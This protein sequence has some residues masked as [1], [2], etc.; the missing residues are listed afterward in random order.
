MNA[1]AAQR[2]LV[3]VLAGAALHHGRSGDEQLSSPLD[4]DRQV[5]RAQPGRAEAGDRAEAGGDHRHDGQV[6]DHVIPAGVHRHVGVPALLQRLHAAAAA[7]ALDEA[8]DRQPQLVGELLGVDLLTRDRGVGRAAANGEVVAADDDLPAVDAACA[9]DEVGGHEAFQL[10]DRVVLS[11]AGQRTD[12]AERAIV[13]QG[14]DPL[15]DG[16]A[17]GVVLPPDLVRAAHALSE[18]VPPAELVQLRLPCH[19]DT[20]ST[21]QPSSIVATSRY[22][23]IDGRG[24]LCWLI[25]D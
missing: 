13:Q 25:R 19:A 23:T 2:L 9:S 1:G 8:D 22:P 12:L 18:F 21:L 11:L 24:M 5:G 3:D 17:A 7:S 14:R 4:Q 15:A 20:Y 6:V 16:Q 10:A